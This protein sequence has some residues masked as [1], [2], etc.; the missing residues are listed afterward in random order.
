MIKET[1]GSS[2]ELLNRDSF[3]SEF[4]LVRAFHVRILTHHKSDPLHFK[5]KIFQQEI[6]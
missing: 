4:L 6:F 2:L 1:S 5:L 3:A